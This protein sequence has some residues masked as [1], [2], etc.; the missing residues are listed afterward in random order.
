MNINW[1]VRRKRVFLFIMLRPVKRTVVTFLLTTIASMLEINDPLFSFFLISLPTN[2][3]NG[4]TAT[5]Y[6]NF[7]FIS[8]KLDKKYVMMIIN[9][10]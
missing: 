7:I 2:Y 10:L 5:G 6:T 1:E 4:R 9:V 3:E 8:E